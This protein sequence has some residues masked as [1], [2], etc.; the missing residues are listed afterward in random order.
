MAW[1]LSINPFPGGG[2][3]GYS[4][5]TD[6]GFAKI[7]EP[8]ETEK[9]RNWSRNKWGMVPTSTQG[10][11]QQKDMWPV[12]IE[13]SIIRSCYLL[14]W[15]NQMGRLS[16]RK[17]PNR[18]AGR[19]P[20][21]RSPF[22]MGQST[23]NGHVQSLFW[24]NQW[25]QDGVF[26]WIS[27]KSTMIPQRHPPCSPIPSVRQALVPTPCA[28][29]PNTSHRKCSWTRRERFDNVSTPGNDENHEKTSWIYHPGNMCQLFFWLPYT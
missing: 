7:V 18:E 20:P 15:R 11:K 24:H 4:K 28:A 5:L 13:I 12:K 6:F 8:G 9:Q 19:I 26:K 2:P 21:R 10:L 25:S 22:S 1:S 17:P 3:N 27:G 29:P 16:E 23:I 14:V